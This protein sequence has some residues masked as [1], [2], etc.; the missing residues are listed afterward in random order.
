MGYSMRTPEY[1]YTEWLVWDCNLMSPMSGCADPS[2]VTPK[3]SQQ[4]GRELYSH[5]GDN[6]TTTF[7]DFEN[8]NLAYQSEYADMV[9]QLHTQ[10]VANWAKPE[11]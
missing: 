10:L 9:A 8:E 11:Q 3:W 2:T 6:S 1:R 5:I 7:A 4:I